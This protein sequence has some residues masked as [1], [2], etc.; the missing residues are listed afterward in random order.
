MELVLEGLYLN[1]LV[2]KDE[3]IGG[4][5]YKDV[6]DDMAKSLRD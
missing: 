3:L 4:R 2:A 5:V 1:T 6:F